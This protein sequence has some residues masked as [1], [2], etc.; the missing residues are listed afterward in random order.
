M[1]F[2]FYP[3]NPLQTLGEMRVEVDGITGLFLAFL[4]YKAPVHSSEARGELSGN[5]SRLQHCE[6]VCCRVHVLKMD[7]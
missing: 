1:I 5:G 3:D 4:E 7:S 2:H 6:A